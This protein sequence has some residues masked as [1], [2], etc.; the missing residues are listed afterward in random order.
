[1]SE[2]R[3]KLPPSFL[4]EVSFNKYYAISWY[5]VSKAPNF[6]VAHFFQLLEKG[7]RRLGSFMTSHIQKA[8]SIEE[9]AEEVA[10]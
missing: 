4:S 2:L 3:D 1:M 10:F 9:E 8:P 6:L 5:V 7:E